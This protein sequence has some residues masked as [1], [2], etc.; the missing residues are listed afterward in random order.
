MTKNSIK[1][2]DYI[3]LFEIGYLI[4]L[5]AVEYINNT[6]KENVVDESSFSYILY[7]W[8][9]KF[10]TFFLYFIEIIYDTTR[11]TNI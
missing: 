11:W 2:L 8:N 5:T 9:N 10:W 4:S 6:F 7:V 3:Y 1:K